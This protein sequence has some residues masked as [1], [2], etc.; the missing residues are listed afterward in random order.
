MFDMGM[1]SSC[2]SSYHKNLHFALYAK[3]LSRII[4]IHYMMNTL[5]TTTINKTS[6]HH[7]STANKFLTLENNKDVKK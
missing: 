3:L 2:T 1:D 6:S 4:Q 5:F 7:G